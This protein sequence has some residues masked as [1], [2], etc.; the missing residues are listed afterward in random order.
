MNILARFFATRAECAQLVAD[1]QEVIRDRDRWADFAVQLT[2]ANRT[3]RENLAFVMARADELREALAAARE[4]LPEAAQESYGMGGAVDNP[5]DFN[6]DPDAC[7][8]TEL[9]AW[10]AACEAWD[11]GEVVAKDRGCSVASN[12]DAAII[13]CRA[14]WGMGSYTYRDPGLQALHA[15]VAKALGEEELDG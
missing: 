8:E 15:R 5:H 9:A 12:G 10:K 4:Y 6:P 14:P 3:Q 7:T 13:A 11:R 1:L 2:E